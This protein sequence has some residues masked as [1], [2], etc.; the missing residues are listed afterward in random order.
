MSVG[1]T[2]QDQQ[3]TYVDRSSGRE[4][5][6]L[7]RYLGHSYQFYFT[8]PCWLDS[9]RSFIFNSERENH[10]D[11]FR[12]D[13]E[14]G[15]ITQLTDST[16]RC[17]RGG[18]LS[19]ATSKLYYW[20]ESGLYEL[21]LDSL[22]ERLVCEIEPGVQPG[23]L[24]ATADGCH[25]CVRLME[26]GG[27]H[28]D[29]RPGPPRDGGSPE[30][31]ESPPLSQVVRIEVGSGQIDV[32]HEDRRNIGHVNTSP[33]RA[34][35]LTF[36]HEGP[37]E[38]VD[39]RIWG[40]NAET[41]RVWPIRPQNG[42]H[43]VVAEHWLAD[44]ERIGFRSHLRATND[45]RFGHIRYDNSDHVESVL[46]AY[47]RHFHTRD[48]SLV[49]GDG[50]PVYPLPAMINTCTTWPYILLYPRDGDGYGTAR[51]LAYHGSTFNV[52]SVHCH[53]H[54]APDGEHVMYTSDT[55]G[56]ANIYLVEIG[57]VG[58]LLELRDNQ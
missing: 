26:E 45:T 21:E 16:S 6:Q 48:G 53:P 10:N 2:F 54:I 27:S 17:I 20:I 11:H 35:L 41:K 12:Y 9:G 56:Y 49:V 33:T 44:G 57:D 5:V 19:T 14:T 4:I 25:L 3:H 32:L 52:N 13:L 8:H 38:Q 7:T 15:L 29:N 39:Q 46:S 22:E 50:S 23:R 42:D 28:V 24:A 51:I 47:S 18:C 1:R 30:L 34:D 43:S 40:V 37:W 31:F 55:K 58:E 36:C